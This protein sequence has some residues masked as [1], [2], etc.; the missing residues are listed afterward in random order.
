M[1]T[2]TFANRQKPI[3]RSG[4][5]GGRAAARARR[6]SRRSPSSTASIAVIVA[7][8]SKAARSRTSRCPNGASLPASPPR[9]AESAWIRST[10]SCVC[11]RQRSSTVAVLGGR[12]TS[13]SVRPVASSRFFSRRF[14]AGLSDVLTGL[15][16]AARAGAPTAPEPV[17]CHIIRSCQTSPVADL[18]T[19]HARHRR[20]LGD[21]QR[22]QVGV[23]V[24]GEVAALAADP[25]DPDP[26][27]GR[28]QVAHEE[29]VD[30]HGAGA[31]RPAD[32]LGPLRRA[33]VD[34]RRE[35]V[36]RRIRE[37]DASASSGKVWTVRTGPNTSRWTISLSFDRGITSG[38]LVE[39]A[40]ALGGL[41]SA[42]DLVAV[43]A[44]ALDE[45]RDAVEMIAVDQR[46]HRR[47]VVARVAE[48]VLVGEAVEEL[49]ERLG[50]RALAR[51]S[52]SRR[53]TPGRR[54]R[55]VLR[56]CAPRPR[57]R[58]RRRRAAGPCRRARR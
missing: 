50:D 45:A 9:P 33:R 58:S 41:A 37:R 20:P 55:T 29:R 52:A 56:P 25:R 10:Y 43:R 18:V 13:R 32:A 44:G 27:E 24:E 51:G 14:V 36:G 47:R 17:S 34:D 2:A 1:P 22:L 28:G 5:R 11:T 30:P 53:G 39:E 48:D 40:A 19:M 38:R 42:D 23:E 8:R 31:N 54:R 12:T 4:R 57:D 26:A 6:R 35:P 3:P 7:A 15:E 49:E 46:R 16:P 21:L